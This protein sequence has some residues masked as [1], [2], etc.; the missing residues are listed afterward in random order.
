MSISAP[1]PFDASHRLENDCG[2]FA[3]TDWLLHH[4][5]Q[6][7]SSG[8]AGCGGSTNPAKA[9]AQTG[10]YFIR[11]VFGLGSAYSTLSKLKRDESNVHPYPL[12]PAR[13]NER[14]IEPSWF[15]MSTLATRHC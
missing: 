14:L 8:S 15:A 3:L 10:L 7:Q 9:L 2:K 11:L 5:C 12:V 13:T 6:A 1:Q 4:A